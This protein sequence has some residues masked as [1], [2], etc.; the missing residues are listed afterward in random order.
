MPA[1]Y[2]FEYIGARRNGKSTNGNEFRVLTKIESRNETSS[3]ILHRGRKDTRSYET[4]FKFRVLQQLFLGGFI[5]KEVEYDLAN[6][7]GDTDV[8]ER[9]VLTQR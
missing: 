4:E 2:L 8:R 7:T 6:G 5:W 9:N 3:S 1:V